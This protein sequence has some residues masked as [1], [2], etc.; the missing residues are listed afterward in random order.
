MTRVFPA[1]EALLG[2]N[3]LPVPNNFMWFFSNFHDWADTKA[4]TESKPEYGAG[5]L[6]ANPLSGYHGFLQR[7]WSVGAYHDA[8]M[9]ET[10][11]AR[12]AHSLHAL[13]F[14][15]FIGCYDVQVGFD[16]PEDDANY[17][18]MAPPRMLVPNINA[19]AFGG[20][21]PTSTISV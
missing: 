16:E 12:C 20:L 3:V 14:A 18:E 17:I 6:V 13:G 1:R 4:D 8:R 10:G 7:G 5:C 19:P 11:V 9:L 2:R 21:Y 15:S